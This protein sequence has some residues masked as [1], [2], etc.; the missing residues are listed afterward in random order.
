MVNYVLNYSEA[1]EADDLTAGSKTSSDDA[2]ND[3]NG[4]PRPDNELAERDAGNFCTESMRWW[5]IDAPNIVFLCQSIFRCF[6]R[7]KSKRCQQ[8]Q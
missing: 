5:T 6:G 1:D 8:T 7:A 2:V 4:S 3:E